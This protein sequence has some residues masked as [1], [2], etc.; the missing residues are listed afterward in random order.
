LQ[1]NIDAKTSKPPFNLLKKSPF[2]IL[3]AL[4]LFLFSFR[5]GDRSLRNPDEGRYAEVAREMVI[6]NDWVEPTLYGVDYLRKPILFY[7]L[8]AFSFKLFGFNE[9]AARGV[10][11]LFG[12]LGVL[13]TYFFVKKTAGEKEA[14]LASILLATNIWYLQVS[15]YLLIDAVFTFFLVLGFYLF[16]LGHTSEKNKNAYYFSFYLSL[17][18]AFLAKG[19]A[20]LV[21]TGISL[22]LYLLITKRVK[23]TLLEMNPALG[24]AL[25]LIV[26][27]PWL[28]LISLHEPEFLQFFFVHEQFTRFASGNFEHQKPF[29]YYFVALFLIFLP[30]ILF[31]PLI[32]KMA[33]ALKHRVASLDFYVLV[34]ALVVLFFYSASKTKLP[35][36]ILPCIPLGCILLAKSLTSWEVFQKKPKFIYAIIFC[37][38]L[39][40]VPTALVVEAKNFN[41]TTKHFAETLKPRLKPSEQVF[42]YGQPGAFYDFA[43]YLN[44]PVKLVGLRGE[45]R[46][47]EGDIVD[48]E[49]KDKSITPEAFFKLIRDGKKIY[50]LMRK[51]D[52]SDLDP[53]IKSYLK[54]LKEDKRKA[55]VTA[56]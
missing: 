22:F 13:T 43:F 45:L 56:A 36:Y 41:Y 31:L 53:D 26:T 18:L 44:Y 1:P 7:W 4:C 30:W 37:L 46:F 54:V 27:L 34:C 29:Y 5:L 50:C 52:F 12:L 25:F 42:I 28:I 21:I 9:W 11:A 32:K 48:D 55:L 47:D 23:Q 24:T 6:N 2:L 19:L 3:F 38:G 20:A 39:S 14:W 49:E 15:R 8:L 16:Y 40:S 17:A 10:P 33:G 51:S 35:T